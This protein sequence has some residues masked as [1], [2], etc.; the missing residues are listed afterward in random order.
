MLALALGRIVIARRGDRGTF[1]CALL[2]G[3]VSTAP[4]ELVLRC[5]I[6]YCVNALTA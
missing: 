1:L 5:P 6:R 3:A 2:A 4:I